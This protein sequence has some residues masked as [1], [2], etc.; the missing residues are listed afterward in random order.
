MKLTNQYLKNSYGYYLDKKKQSATHC[1]RLR[2]QRDVLSVAGLMAVRAFLA[3]TAHSPNVGLM[4][5]NVADVGLTVKQHW[6]S[7]SL[8]WYLVISS[9][10]DIN[11]VKVYS[12]G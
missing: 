10:A 6:A 8:E 9:G 5:A 7:F 2:D 3:N 1:T 11:A 12:I 4:S